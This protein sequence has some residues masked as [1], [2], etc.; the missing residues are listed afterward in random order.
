MEGLRC[1]AV[2]LGIDYLR[3]HYDLDAAAPP[4]TPATTSRT[5]SACCAADT[6]PRASK[7]YAEHVAGV[8]GGAVVWTCDVEEPRERLVELATTADQTVISEGGPGTLDEITML[9]AASPEIFEEKVFMTNISYLVDNVIPSE[10]AKLTPLD[11]ETKEVYTY[12]QTQFP[13]ISI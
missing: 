11:V 10:L 3:T 8:G 6:I 2:Q 12:F 13:T 7:P 1:T 5:I 4:P 9:Y